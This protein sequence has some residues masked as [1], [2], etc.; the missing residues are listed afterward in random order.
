MTGRQPDEKVERLL[1][2]EENVI[3]AENKRQLA[4]FVLPVVNSAPFENFFNNAKT[5]ILGRLQ[6][7]ATLQG[8]VRRSNFIEVQRQEISEKM[9]RLAFNVAASAKLFEGLDARAT[10]MWKRPP[11]C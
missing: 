8:K 1:F 5:P 7:L 9:D 6:R 10:T 3:G 4:G 2:V 11:R